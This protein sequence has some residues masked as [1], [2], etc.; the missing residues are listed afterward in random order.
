MIGQSGWVQKGEADLLVRTAWVVAGAMLASQ[1][2]VL[3]DCGWSSPPVVVTVRDILFVV[4][5][6]AA[7]VR[8]GR[9]SDNAHGRRL[10]PAAAA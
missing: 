8:L 4:W 7:A 10:L 1:L 9:S 5:L 3:S 6:I 2:S